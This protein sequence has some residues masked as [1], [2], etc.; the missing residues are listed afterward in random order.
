VKLVTACG[1]TCAVYLVCTIFVC[2]CV[3][4]AASKVGKVNLYKLHYV[5]SLFAYKIFSGYYSFLCH[6]NVQW[7]P[8]RL[9]LGDPEGLYTALLEVR[10]ACLRKCGRFHEPEP[11]QWDQPEPWAREFHYSVG[12]AVCTH[13]QQSPWVSAAQARVRKPLKA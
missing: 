5:F 8:K 10:L 6:Y 2:L 9:C 7:G 13:W 11:K 3:S 1:L 12:R 4:F